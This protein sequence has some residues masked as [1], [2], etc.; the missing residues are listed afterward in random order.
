MGDA[1]ASS[2]EPSAI[3]KVAFTVMHNLEHQHDWRALELCHDSNQPRPLI[4]GFPPSRL[5]LHPDDQVAALE[6]EKATGLKV[7]L[8]PEMESVLAVHLSEKLSLATFASVFDAVRERRPQPKR[9]VLAVLH[10][11]STVVYYLMHEG[12]VKPRQN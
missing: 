11:D 6:R 7:H 4:R 5:Y 8:E 12:M 3:D 9:I 2:R 1:A 10:N